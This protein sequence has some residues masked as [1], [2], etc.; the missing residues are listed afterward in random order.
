VSGPVHH[1]SC[2]TLCPFGGAWFGGEG[3]PHRTV[4]ICCH[5][6]LVESSDGL[7]LVDTGFGTGDVANPKRLGAAFRAGVRPRPDMAETALTRV[8]EAGH[9]PKDVRHIV[10]THLDLDHAGGLGDFPDAKVHVFSAELDAALHPKLSERQRYIGDQWAHGPDWV[11]HLEGGDEWF[12][13]ASAQ[14]IEGLEDQIAI[15][16]VIGHTRGHSAIA[17]REGEG[18]TLHCGDAYFHHG[19]MQTPPHAPPGLAFF[20]RINDADTKSRKAN[21]ERL[22]ELA[23]SHGDEV[24]LINAHDPSYLGVA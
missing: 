23:R 16:P 12:G 1:F 18:W 15:I 21:Q 22:R 7:V 4:E 11:A 24:R 5:V 17:V 3:G 8:R 14:A 13:F 6:L 2:G 19:E 10:L 9:D 20:Q